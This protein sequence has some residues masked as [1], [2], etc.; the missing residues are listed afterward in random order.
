MGEDI[1]R[2]S[3]SMIKRESDFVNVLFLLHYSDLL[4]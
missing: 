2:R 1:W 3:M 4:S